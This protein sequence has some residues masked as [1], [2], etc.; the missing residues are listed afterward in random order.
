M[1]SNPKQVELSPYEMTDED[2]AQLSTAE[3]N[4]IIHHLP[5]E[6]LHE[7]PLKFFKDDDLDLSSL[8]DDQINKGIFDPISVSSSTRNLRMGY[9][10]RQAFKQIFPKLKGDVFKY[11]GRLRIRDS[12]FVW[13][14]KREEIAALFLYPDHYYTEQFVN[15]LGPKNV[16]IIQE[17]NRETLDTLMPKMQGKD[18]LVIPS[19]LPVFYKQLRWDTVTDDQILEIQVKGSDSNF[20]AIL[21][22]LDIQR[23]NQLYPKMTSAQQGCIPL[24]HLKNPEFKSSGS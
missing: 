22:C 3:L 1:G 16:A 18:L 5:L 2:I 8:S 4:K 9:M 6:R 20:I 17:L 21:E 14:D 11:V 13:P 23:I 7:L 24:K 12:D 19:T 10:R 15:V